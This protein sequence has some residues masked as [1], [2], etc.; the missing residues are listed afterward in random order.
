MNKSVRF[1]GMI[2]NSPKIKS[3]NQ[4]VGTENEIPS[5]SEIPNFNRNRNSYLKNKRQQSGS[6]Y[7]A[8]TNNTENSN[9]SS[10]MGGSLAVLGGRTN[11][12]N[13]AENSYSTNLNQP[14]S[15]QSLAGGSM[16]KAPALLSNPHDPGGEPIG[17]P[18]PV[19][20][21]LPYLI[22]F[23]ILY[24]LYIYKFRLKIS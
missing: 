19:G 4:S 8:I 18:L 24:I 20:D 21:G 23:S 6:E 9:T 16:Q 14:F 5:A 1:D 13:S 10:G 22:G 12:S 3:S 17:A 15:D 7:A 11:N 2:A